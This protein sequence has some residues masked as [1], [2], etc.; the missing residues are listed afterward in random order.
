MWSIWYGPQGTPHLKRKVPIREESAGSEPWTPRGRVGKEWDGIALTACLC[1]KKPAKVFAL[2]TGGCGSEFGLGKKGEN[3]SYQKLSL[4][5]NN[6][7]STR[8][9]VN[10]RTNYD[11]LLRETC[12]FILHNVLCRRYLTSKLSGFFCVILIPDQPELIVHMSCTMWLVLHSSEEHQGQTLSEEQSEHSPK[13]TGQSQQCWTRLTERSLWLLYQS[14]WEMSQESLLSPL[15]WQHRWICEMESHEQNAHKHCG[16]AQR[17]GIT[18]SSLTRP[19]G[20]T[21]CFCI[22]PVWNPF[23]LYLWHG[24]TRMPTWKLI[25]LAGSFAFT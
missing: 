16:A 1:V 21:F 2:P 5:R 13:Q 10:E 24:S 15:P 7:L 20:F 9:G 17:Q 23:K 25:F 11:A 4:K 8:A 14:P 6:D 3:C 18:H 19:A 12:T 22:P